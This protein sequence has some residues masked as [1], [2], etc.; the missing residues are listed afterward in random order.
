MN[1]FHKFCKLIQNFVCVCFPQSAGDQTMRLHVTRVAK[2]NQIIKRI[3][4]FIIR[5]PSSKAVNVVNVDDSIFLPAF[6]ASNRVSSESFQI[7]WATL[8]RCFDNI[9]APG[10]AIFLTKTSSL[11][12][13]Q[14][15]PASKFFHTFWAKLRSVVCGV[16]KLAASRTIF[17]VRFLFGVSIAKLMSFTANLP[18]MVDRKLVFA[19]NTL[20]DFFSHFDIIPDRMEVI[21]A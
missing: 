1:L 16:I 21:N 17:I 7:V 10:A 8:D 11:N 18:C 14:T 19:V 2:S 13:L 20:S 6:L 12:A 15:N 5:M 9:T 4:L 3:V